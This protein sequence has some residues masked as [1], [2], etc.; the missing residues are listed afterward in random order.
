M[1]STSINR[2]THFLRYY[3]CVLRFV[4]W[5]PVKSSN[6]EPLNAAIKRSRTIFTDQDSRWRSQTTLQATHMWLPLDHGQSNSSMVTTTTETTHGLTYPVA[7]AIDITAWQSV[8]TVCLCCLTHGVCVSMFVY[9][10]QAWLTV[11]VYACVFLFVITHRSTVLS[12]L[13]SNLINKYNSLTLAPNVPCMLLVYL[14]YDLALASLTNGLDSS[15]GQTDG[16]G[17]IKATSNHYSKEEGYS[18][19]G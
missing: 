4:L 17:G 3:G 2:S 14:L 13:I 12:I 11:P 10:S 7:R 15:S 9:Y 19:I 1:N 8:D 6:R 5:T 18:F 16:N